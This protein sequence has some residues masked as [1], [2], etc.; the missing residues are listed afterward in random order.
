MMRLKKTVLI[1]LLLIPIIILSSCNI[2]KVGEEKPYSYGIYP[3]DT[4]DKIT[5]W[6][7]L[8]D[9]LKGTVT[10]YGETEFAKELSKRTGV[11]VE[12]IHPTSGNDFENLNIM[13]ATDNMPDIIQADWLGINPAAMLE[14]GVIL[15]LN[16]YLEYMP[17]LKAYLDKHPDVYKQITT[18]NGDIYCFP[19]IREDKLLLTTSGFIIRSD[20]MKELELEIPETIEEWEYVLDKLKTKCDYPL[21][22]SVGMLSFFSSGFGISSEYY[23]GNDGKVTHGF[24]QPQYKDFLI[25]MNRWYEK[26]FLHK[27]SSLFDIEML[28]N[29]IVLGYSAVDFTAGGSGMGYYLGKEDNNGNP[30]IMEPVPYPSTQ[31][32]LKSEFGNSVFEYSGEAGAAITSSAKNP[33]LCAK[34]LDYNY[35][36][37][38]AMLNNFGIEGVSYEMI[39]GVPVFTDLIT[40][41]PDGLIISKALPLYVRSSTSGPFVQD[42]RYITQ[43]YRS[44]YQVK[45]LEVWGNTNHLQHKIPQITLTPQETKELSVINEKISDYRYEMTNRFIM[46]DISIDEFDKTVEHCKTLGIDRA[47]E[48]YQNA[49]NRYNLR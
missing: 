23:I 32:G 37:D 1:S 9:V 24:L 17:N 29:N 45:A 33:E 48:I 4:D 14:N 13:I 8:P 26:G 5:Y 15:R 39:E 42:V 19:F 46:G 28:R 18:D 6:L 38:G 31:K 47:I 36:E 44:P 2:K 12:Y 49:L 21:A 27:N 10:N 16:D 35:S 3:I 30:I 34:F 41:N 11:E 25:T 7:S 22:F 20:W 43:Y 40:K